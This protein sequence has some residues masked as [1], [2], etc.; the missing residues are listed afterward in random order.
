MVLSSEID[1]P[2]FIT[3]IVF[4]ETLDGSTPLAG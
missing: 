1:E 3:F 2:Q 4:I